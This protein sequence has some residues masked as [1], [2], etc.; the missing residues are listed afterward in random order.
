MS[1]YTWVIGIVGLII[2]VVYL[3]WITA[4]IKRNAPG[5][6]K[7]PETVLS[8]M[9]GG[10]GIII[11]LLLC[12]GFFLLAKMDRVVELLIEI[13]ALLGAMGG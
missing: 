12:V 3:I 6:L 9:R 2:F 4:K 8:A 5:D 7:N 10:N 13:K 1:I 11:G